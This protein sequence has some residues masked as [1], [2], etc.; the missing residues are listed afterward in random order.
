MEKSA[1]EK[2]KDIKNRISKGLPTT[3]SERNIFNIYEKKR[4]KKLNQK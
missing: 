4:K 2:L 3:F 1:Y